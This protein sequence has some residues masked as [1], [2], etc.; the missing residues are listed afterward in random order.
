MLDR[1]H[2]AVWCRLGPRLS[3]LAALGVTQPF[4]QP[5]RALVC[6]FD[7]QRHPALASLP[8]QS[9]RF[10]EETRAETLVA[11]AAEHEQVRKDA[12]RIDQQMTDRKAPVGE[13]DQQ[14]AIFPF[15]RGPEG[16]VNLAAPGGQRREVLLRRGADF[17]FHD[18]AN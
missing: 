12:A 2:R 5:D 8:K 16:P 4:I 15:E 9:L 7:H 14:D 18:Q 17:S 3:R 10:H 1:L 13:R 6:L 11:K